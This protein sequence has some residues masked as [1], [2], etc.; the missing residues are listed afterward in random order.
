MSTPH[1]AAAAST[2]GYYRYP[3]LHGDTLLFVCEDDI[4]GVH[5][6]LGGRAHRVTDAPGPVRRPVI[7]RVDTKTNSHWS[8]Y[9]PVRAVNAVH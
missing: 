4:Y 1:H 5:A 2:D 3:A 9:A 6:T 7:R 8:P